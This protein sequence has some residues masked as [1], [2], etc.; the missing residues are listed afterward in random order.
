MYSIVHDDHLDTEAPTVFCYVS[1]SYLCSIV[2]ND[3]FDAKGPIVLL[4][5]V[6]FT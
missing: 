1:Q 6:S 5:Y 2:H 4:Y 3:T